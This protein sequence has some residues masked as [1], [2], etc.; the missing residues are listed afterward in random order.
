[1]NTD[2]DEDLAEILRILMGDG[3]LY[4]NYEK[5]QYQLDISLNQVDEPRYFQHV[6][7]LF[8]S[9]FQK[10]IRICDQTGKAVS[11]RYYSKEINQFL[12]K[13][14]LTPGNKSHNQ[15]SVP[16]VILQEI[17]LINRCLKGLFDTDGSITIDND[18]DL[19]LTF[20]NCSKPLVI[21]FYN[22]CLKIGI[23]PSPKIQ[24]N[25]KRKAWR[26]LIAKKNEISQFLKMVCLL[27]TSPSPRDRS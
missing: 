11:L 1:M 3:N 2:I 17:L 4:S 22:M 19:R 15:I 8:E 24:F 12:T 23:I 14:G 16:E 25:R 9:K 10:D 7:N 26:V 6:K 21:D 27:Y 13:T 18:K 20:S 5:W